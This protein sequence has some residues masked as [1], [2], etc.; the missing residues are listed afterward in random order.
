M[1]IVVNKDIF[2]TEF[3][4]ADKPALVTYLNERDIYEQTLT[5]PYPYTETDAD[6]FF[7]IDQKATADQGQPTNFAIRAA[8]DSLLGG[9]G[10]KELAIGVSHRADLGYWVA[11]PFWG[12]GIMSAVV[13]RACARGFA[14]WGLSKIGAHVFAGNIASARVLEKCGFQLEGCLRKHYLK[15][16]RFID[17]LV[18]GLVK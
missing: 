4:P 14:V 6:A 18:Y 9:I 7:R 5:L 11:K 8:D 2:L 10:F 15:D 1:Q 16:K 17:A 3:R 12:R 13:A